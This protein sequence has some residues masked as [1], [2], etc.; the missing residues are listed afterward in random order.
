MNYDSDKSLRRPGKMADSIDGSRTLPRARARRRP[1]DERREAIL[2]A[3]CRVFAAASYRS[4]GTVEIA[5]EAGVGEPTLYRYFSDKRA[6][7]LGVLRRCR[8]HVLT[9]WSRAGAG[10]PNCLQA[11]D[12]MGVWYFE[13][14]R[15]DP[16]PVRV[17]AR[18]AADSQEEDTRELLRE[19]YARILE[20]VRD[21]LARAQGEGLIDQEVNVDAAAW[22]FMAVGQAIDL[23]TLLGMEERLDDDVF[24]GIQQL[25]ARAL[26][27]GRREGASGRAGLEGSIPSH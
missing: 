27:P 23:V 6:L 15:R 12:A 11:L 18:A 2:Q 24:R 3:A 21:L 9:E 17:R 14:A 4:A 25:F 22:L 26:G 5:H 20:F 1:A 8:D 19:G 10:Q 7:Y 13:N 16:D